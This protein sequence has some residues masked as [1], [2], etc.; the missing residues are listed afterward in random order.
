MNTLNHTAH[1]L[2]QHHINTIPTRADT[3]KAPAITWK[4]WTTNPIPAT[5]IDQWFPQGTNHGL[6]IITGTISGNLE[7]TEIEGNHTH[8]LQTLLT[9]AN[10]NGTRPLFDR[11]T[12][13][14]LEQSPSGGYHWIYRLTGTDVPGNQKL[15]RTTNRD[16]IAE[17]RGQGGYFIAA[18]TN[19]THHQTGN[20]WTRINGGPETIAT[21]T[22]TEREQFHHLFRTLN[23]EPTPQPTPA[24]HNPARTPTR[25][26]HQPGQGSGP[27]EPNPANT[28]KQKP[29]GTPS[30]PHTAGPA[31]APTTKAPPTGSAPEKTPT[32]PAPTANPQ[33][34]AT[35][36]TATVSTS[37]PPPPPSNPKRP[38]PNSAP[39]PC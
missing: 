31:Y 26:G 28:S 24:A 15:A 39:G 7:M 29:A 22:T 36:K 38:T 2:N 16:V 6:A 18:P 4:H 13:G 8:Q 19:G 21:I 9:T 27:T 1:T 10:T 17:T 11:I 5:N 23:Q 32:T 34:P 3:T 33:P 20:P 25:P 14:W 30:S 37:S 12:N 35:P